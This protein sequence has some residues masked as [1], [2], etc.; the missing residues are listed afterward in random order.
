MR[1]ILANCEAKRYINDELAITAGINFM[2]V[3]K[4]YIQLE[5]F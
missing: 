4:K 1:L 5:W 3:L 2:T